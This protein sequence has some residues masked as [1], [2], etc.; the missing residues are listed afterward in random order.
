MMKE[1]SCIALKKHF[2]VTMTRT[3]FSSG[4]T[5]RTNTL[6]NYATF[7]HITNTQSDVD[8]IQGVPEQLSPHIILAGTTFLDIY[9]VTAHSREW[10]FRPK[11]FYLL[12]IRSL[13]RRYPHFNFID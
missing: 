9:Q 2:L 6:P 11:I 1:R 4:I 3:Y 10:R 13:P 8:S 7:T 5:L 12:W